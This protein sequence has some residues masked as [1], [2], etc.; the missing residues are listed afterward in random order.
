MGWCAYLRNNS[1][2]AEVDAGDASAREGY[3]NAKTQFID[4]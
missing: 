4:V 3:A 1:F 2:A